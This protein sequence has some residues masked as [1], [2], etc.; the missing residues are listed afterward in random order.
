MMLAGGFYGLWEHSLGCAVTAG[1]IAKKIDEPNPEEI[2][3]AALL[4]D[5]GKV[6]IR[7]ELP[8][9]AS[10]IDKAAA[11]EQVSTYEAEE[12]ILGI[13]HATI[14][15]WLCKEWYLPKKLADP[16]TYHHNPTLSRFAQ[17]PTAIVHTANALVRGIG[18]GFAGDNLVPQ[19]DA[20]AWKTLDISDSLLKEIVSEMDE[21]LEDAEDFLSGK[22]AGK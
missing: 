19:I 22:S 2:C 9:E 17:R 4:H 12:N 8:E 7:I 18:F 15:N 3:I 1:V 21:K 16:I 20:E 6:I 13:T 11:D 14:G 5:I 10:L